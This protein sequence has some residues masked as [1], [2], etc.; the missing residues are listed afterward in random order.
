[1]TD[2]YRVWWVVTVRKDGS[3]GEFGPFILDDATAALQMVMLSGQ[4]R[5]GKLER[6]GGNRWRPRRA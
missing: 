6:S 1:M 2:P 4:Y 5:S 3:C